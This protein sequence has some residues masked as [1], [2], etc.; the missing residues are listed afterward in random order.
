MQVLPP[1]FTAG[2][3][4]GTGVGVGFATAGAGAAALGVRRVPQ[5]VQKWADATTGL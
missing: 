3:G 1:V 2:V 4:V 5:P